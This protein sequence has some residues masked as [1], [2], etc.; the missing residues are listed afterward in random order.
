MSG[1]RKGA[2]AAVLLVVGFCS[3]QTR[4]EDEPFCERSNKSKVEIADADATILGFKIGTSTLKEVQAK[5]GQAKPTPVSREE[6]SDV[7]IC[8]ISPVDGTVLVFYTGVMGGDEDV[9]RFAL[10]S[11]Q[12]AFPRSSQCTSS[13][14]ISHS[15]STKSGIRLG[16]TKEDFETIA[17]KPISPT[18]NPVK[19]E[20]LCRSKMTEDEIKGFK[21]A[22]NWDVSADSYFDRTSWIKAWYG[23][24]TISRV[25]VGEI[26]S[27]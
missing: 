10:W 23:K 8:Y 22:N 5:L 19:Y 24:A 16:L 2:V 25:E 6:E 11:R 12:A 26:E 17:G 15:L 21:S 1:L 3:A 4:R 27:Y 7:S 13:N 20:Y 9:T 18:S 14:V